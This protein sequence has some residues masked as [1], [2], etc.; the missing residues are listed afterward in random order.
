MVLGGTANM[1]D[2]HKRCTIGAHGAIGGFVPRGGRRAC[3]TPWS[4]RP[5]PGN[6]SECPHGSSPSSCR[7][8][9]L[10]VRL[11]PRWSSDVLP[12]CPSLPAIARC[13]LRRT[14]TRCTPSVHFR[15]PRG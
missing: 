13:R 1:E 4:I 12:A 8:R 6:H 7:R 3:R 11:E 15:P 5:P 9:H 2:E 10:G 14:W